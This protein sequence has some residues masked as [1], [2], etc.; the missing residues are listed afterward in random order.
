M[1]IYLA[2]SNKCPTDID[3]KPR[4]SDPQGIPGITLY[5][6]LDAGDSFTQTCLPVAIQVRQGLE[7]EW[8]G[9]RVEL[10]AY[11]LLALACRL[12]Q[13]IKAG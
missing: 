4:K 3:G 10:R 1:Q 9:S 8:L 7:I 11:R 13:L 6:S 12:V 2:M 5:T